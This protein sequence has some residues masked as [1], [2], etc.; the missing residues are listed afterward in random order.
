M[1]LLCLV[2]Y[3]MATT[4][5]VLTIRGLFLNYTSLRA[6]G[7]ATSS[8]LESLTGGDSCALTHDVIDELMPL[9]GSSCE[10]T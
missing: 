8:C 10:T 7:K 9:I 1:A 5:W 3:A 6:V 4:H 2:M